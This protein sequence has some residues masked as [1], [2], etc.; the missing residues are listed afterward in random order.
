ME[1]AV[2]VGSTTGTIPCR[3]GKAMIWNLDYSWLTLMVACVGILAFILA[4]ALDAAIWTLDGDFLGCGVATWT[5]E[6]LLA[7][8]TS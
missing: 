8:L 5:A 7:E 1:G 6:T 4:L 3:W 2:G